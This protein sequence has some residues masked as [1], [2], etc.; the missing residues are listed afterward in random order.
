MRYFNLI[1]F[2]DPSRFNDSILH[3]PA[4]VRHANEMNLHESL[5]TIFQPSLGTMRKINPV[6]GSVSKSF[7]LRLSMEN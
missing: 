3:L 1:R 7:I 6:Q 5:D 4:Y 2:N